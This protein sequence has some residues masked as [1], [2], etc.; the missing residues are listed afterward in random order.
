MTNGL[1]VK[2]GLGHYGKWY[3]DNHA[4]DDFFIRTSLGLGY[5]NLKSEVSVLPFIGRRWFGGQVYA[6]HAGA[7]VEWN[8]WLSP[9]LR[10]LSAVEIGRNQH[11]ERSFL[12]G[13]D[14]SWSQSLLFLTNANRYW[15]VGGDYNKTTAKD[16]SEAY[17]RHSARLALGQAWR[18]GLA[19]QVQMNLAKRQYQE[20]DFFNINRKDTEYAMGISLWHNA[21][22]VA[23]LTP[24]L[25]ASWQKTDSNH[26]L[27]DHQKYRMM[28]EMNR[29][30]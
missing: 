5:K 12:N 6:N 14:Y 27:Y 24:R 22:R 26:F 11:P 7:R 2:F 29:H 20:Q 19:A 21:I 30:F 23:G 9:K 3:W 13:Q 1:N 8:Q 25:T 10:L 28:L 15:L 16:A 18:S 4:Y 17:V